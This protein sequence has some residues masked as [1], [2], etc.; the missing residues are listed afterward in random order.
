VRKTRKSEVAA[1]CAAAESGIE[2]ARSARHAAR[3][4][5]VEILWTDRLKA[6]NGTTE[7]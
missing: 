1:V 7:Y 4:H 3:S 2:T 5:P 6:V